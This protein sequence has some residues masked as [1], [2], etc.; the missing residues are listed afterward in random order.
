MPT[1][2]MLVTSDRN[3]SARYA[4]PEALA[5]PTAGDGSSSRPPTTARTNHVVSAPAGA[6]VSMKSVVR[7]RAVGV[8]RTAAA[9]PDWR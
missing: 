4:V 3:L 7:T 5:T 9:L 8:S 1:W 6:D 2:E